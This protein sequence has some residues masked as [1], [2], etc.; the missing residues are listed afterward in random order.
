MVSQAELISKAITLLSLHVLS[1]FFRDGIGP[2]NQIA[3][4]GPQ[5]ST[6]T[7][8]F[9]AADKFYVTVKTRRRLRLTTS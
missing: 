2:F 7:R 8:G 3:C 9:D 4:L 5:Y 6:R 1:Q